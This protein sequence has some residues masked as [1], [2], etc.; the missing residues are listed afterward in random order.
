M[1]AFTY[2][3]NSRTKTKILDATAFSKRN[4]GDSPIYSTQGEGKRLLSVLIHYCLKLESKESR[5]F[6]SPQILGRET[7]RDEE[8]MNNLNLLKK[9]HGQA[10]Q[11]DPIDEGYTTLKELS[12]AL[13]KALD[14]V[15][16]FEILKARQ[17]PNP[18]QGIDFYAE[19]ERFEITLIQFALVQARG[20]QKRA[21]RLLG[22]KP[23]TLN[24]KIKGYN[25]DWKT[26][27]QVEPSSAA[28]VNP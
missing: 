4:F 2:T 25:L 19:V 24:N 21:A 27:T 1:V 3:P 15:S 23:T 10:T 14:A 8:A 28:H 7:K 16:I 18:T 11:G 20:S 12:S 22:L 9:R 13:T 17:I 5:T 26:I 6:G